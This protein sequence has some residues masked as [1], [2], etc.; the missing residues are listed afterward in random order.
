[1]ATVIVP[2]ACRIQS[3]RSD[4]RNPRRIRHKRVCAFLDAG[5]FLWNVCSCVGKTPASA[6]RLRS[7]TSALNM[8]A[9]PAILIPAVVSS[10]VVWQ[11][12]RRVRRNI[13][14]QP[15]EPRRLMVRIG[16]FGLIGVLLA[17][18]SLEHARLLLGFAA[19]LL[20]GMGLAWVG[21]R[22]TRF[23]TTAEGRFYTPNMYLGIA[24]S[25]LMVGRLVYRL[26]LPYG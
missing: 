18:L 22:L 8:P 25:L 19:G 6:S 24:L 16:I 13:G 15:F 17:G 5:F 21:L 20:P 23:E 10:L 14:I 3:D 2:S 1:M 4:S 26:T 9:A 12:Y 7:K 11:V